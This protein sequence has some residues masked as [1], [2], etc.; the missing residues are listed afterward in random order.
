M[1]KPAK[2][3]TMRV[4]GK[5]LMLPTKPFDIDKVDNI[6]SLLDEMKAS[7]EGYSRIYYKYLQNSCDIK[8]FIQSL[9]QMPHWREIEEKIFSYRSVEDYTAYI[10][11]ESQNL[12]FIPFSDNYL[13]QTVLSDKRICQLFLERVLKRSINNVKPRVEHVVQLA[14]FLHGIRLDVCV[15]LDD[16]SL[17]DV[18]M[19]VASQDYIR[20][21]IVAYRSSLVVDQ[22]RKEHKDDK[23]FYRHIRPVVVIF[24]CDF[25]P[26]N[27]GDRVI[28]YYDVVTRHDGKIAEPNLGT[29][30]IINLRGTDDCGLDKELDE[31]RKA[32]ISN[33]QTAFSNDNELV[34]LFNK[35]AT[36]IQRNREWR[37]KKMSLN[38]WEADVFTKGMERGSDQ[39]AEQLLNAL[40]LQQATKYSALAKAF[41]MSKDKIVAQANALGVFNSDLNV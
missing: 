14:R 32:I 4:S 29:D 38:F 17:V 3:E 10:E 34:S 31:F 16:G 22:L 6:F 11:M 27:V 21:R 40:L 20:Q 9:K 23:A 13:F 37:L 36:A 30:V 15:E 7:G 35:K 25:S 19:Q 26:K 39:K 28:T 8:G 2:S 12:K 1:K 5:K 24:I 18:E 33:G 41:E